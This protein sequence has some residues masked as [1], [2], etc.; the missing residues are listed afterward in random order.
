M[1]IEFKDRES[2]LILRVH[3]E[4][5]AYEL[6]VYAQEGFHEPVSVGFTLSKKELEVLIKDLQK[7]LE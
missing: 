3:K 2:E 7:L 1:K 4:H 5:S 6:T